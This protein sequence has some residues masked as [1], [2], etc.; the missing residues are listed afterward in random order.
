MAKAVLA[1]KVAHKVASKVAQMGKIIAKAVLPGINRVAH[2]VVSK[3]DLVVK[4]M[5]K[6][7]IP[8][9]MVLHQTFKMVAGTAVHL[10]KV[11]NTKPS[12]LIPS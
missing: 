12:A 2:K 6:T 11:A 5:V 4:A 8:E 9:T 7:V 3:A 1:V 10:I